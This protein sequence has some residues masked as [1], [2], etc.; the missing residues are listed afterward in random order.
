MIPVPFG[1]SGVPLPAPLDDDSPAVT[2]WK[3]FLRTT[4][5]ERVIV[6]DWNAQFFHARLRG[7]H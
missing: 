2:A 1:K 7:V 3:G 4:P 5:D 6:S